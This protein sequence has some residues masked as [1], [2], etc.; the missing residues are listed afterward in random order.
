MLRKIKEKTE[1][2]KKSSKPKEEQSFLSSVGSLLLIIVIVFAFKSS[3]LDA[4]N[5]PSGSMIPTLKIGDF[6]FVN[7]MRYSFRMPFTEKEL[8]RFD[9]PK[10]GDIVTFIPPPEATHDFRNPGQKMETD[11][12]GMFSKRFVKRI[13]GLPGDT[14][15]VSQRYLTNYKGEK[16]D[17]FF[18]EYKEKGSNE[19]QSFEPIPVAPKD[20]LL[21]LDNDKS[22]G[23]SLF[24]EKKGNF[25]HYVLEGGSPS[26][27]LGIE[28]TNLFPIRFSGFNF[29]Y[30]RNN[31]NSGGICKIPEDYYMVMGDNRDD[32]SDSRIWGF[33]KRENILGKAMI[34]YFSINWKD[35]TCMYKN[36][37]RYSEFGIDL[38]KIYDEEE[39]QKK[40]YHSTT[41]SEMPLKIYE[42][43]ENYFPS[44]REIRV[45]STTG[46]KFY[47]EMNFFQNYNESILTWIDRTL[48][49]RIWRMSVR[50]SRIGNILK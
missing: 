3:I 28:N 41:Y 23:R 14:L 33:V 15:R 6:L 17:Y 9:D 45:D 43:D 44:G 38:N 30:L 36:D 11:L 32:S 24:K 16:V 2:N 5:I 27:I 7:K 1:K 22:V 42:G 19:F 47:Y 25:E 26:D 4:N 12:P 40:C 37:K 39:L 35:N 29:T 46:R 31:C 48:R 20:E 8:I 34:I 50:W 18:F 49:Y 13:V 10:R 21:D